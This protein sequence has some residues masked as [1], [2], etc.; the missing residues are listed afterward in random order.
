MARS[1]LPALAATVS[2]IDCVNRTDLDGLTALLHADHELLVLDEPP[3]VGRDANVEA[4]RGYFTAFPEYVIYPRMLVEHGLRVTV[5]GNTTGSH[6]NLPDE[7]ELALVVIWIAEVDHGRL[8]RWQV[9]EDT[10]GVRR[11]LGLP[12]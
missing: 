6:L 10:A 3:I 9:C 5:L 1:P 7:E 2:F 12:L 4:W 11:A 8:S